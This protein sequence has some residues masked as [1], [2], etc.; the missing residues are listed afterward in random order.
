MDKIF[1]V[2]LIFVLFLISII[3]LS[4]YYNLNLHIAMAIFTLGII[5]IGLILIILDII[6]SDGTID[7]LN[8]FLT[9]INHMVL[10]NY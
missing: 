6:F 5:F 7:D 9:S 1:L 2:V 4:F 8:R 10:T 3:F